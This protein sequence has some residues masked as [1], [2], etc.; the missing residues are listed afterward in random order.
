LAVPAYVAAGLLQDVAPQAASELR[1]IRY[2]STGTVSLGFR[3]DEIDHPLDG[4]GLLIPRSEERPLNALTWT[5]TK[6]D[7]RS[8]QDYVLLRAFFGGSRRPEMMGVSDEELA[9]TVQA[10][11]RDLMGITA[12]PVFHRIY[13]WFNANPQYDVGHLQRVRAI[14]EALPSN[15]FVT[16]SPYRGIGIPDC[17]H[18]AQETVRLCLQESMMHMA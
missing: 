17:V 12:E 10:E 8:P 18:Q 2:V 7:Q 3:S 5:S 15:V 9:S 14:E 16:G 4:F 11:L 1:R 6:F 13:R